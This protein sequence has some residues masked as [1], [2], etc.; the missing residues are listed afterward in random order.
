MNFSKTAQKVIKESIPSKDIKSN[1]EK[2]VELEMM[3]G[4]LFIFFGI[5]LSIF[6]PVS[7]KIPL[8][9]FVFSLIGI[10]FLLY[11]VG[12]PALKFFS[13]GFVTPIE[14]S[15]MQRPYSL[16]TVTVISPEREKTIT[17]HIF[18]K[19]GISVNLFSKV[20]GG[21]EGYYIIPEGGF[22]IEGGSV[23]CLY[24]PVRFKHNQLPEPIKQAMLEIPEYKI[25]HQL[26]MALFPTT[27]NAQIIR[28]AFSDAGTINSVND[29]IT[30]LKMAD[31][32]ANLSD[33]YRRTEMIMGADKI[34]GTIKRYGSKQFTEIHDE[35]EGEE[36]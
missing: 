15:S 22:I 17:Y 1:P 31:E 29:V 36:K 30:L 32:H 11:A 12:V 8:L 33:S 5:F 7:L 18:D 23:T 27:V 34:K 9:L 3:I 35:D 14:H 28:D 6:D 13:I 24:K 20:G 25:G 10:T 26:Y 21:R 4:M 2:T 19:G 16:K